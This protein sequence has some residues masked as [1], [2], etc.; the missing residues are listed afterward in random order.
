[1]INIIFL[2][3]LY[4]MVVGNLKPDHNITPPISAQISEP[5]S[6]IPT[7]SVARDGKMWFESRNIKLEE[8]RAELSRETNFEK[9]KIHADANVDALTIS[10]IMNVSAEAGIYQFVLITKSTLD[11][12]SENVTFD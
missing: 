9:L 5:P 1:M 10:K 2:L 6:T 12:T 11:A 8:L 4:F 3:L 7:I